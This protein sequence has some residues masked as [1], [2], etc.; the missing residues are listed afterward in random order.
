MLSDSREDEEFSDP[1][2]NKLLDRKHLEKT[3]AFFSPNQ[4]QMKA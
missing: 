4:F 3:Q 2:L 1:K